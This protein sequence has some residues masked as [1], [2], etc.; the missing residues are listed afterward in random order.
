MRQPKRPK[1]GDW[2]RFQRDGDLV[3][4]EV[5]YVYDSDSYIYD[6]T[7]YTVRS[8]VA[9]DYCEIRPAGSGEGERGG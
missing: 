9:H 1:P 7:A 5:V 6:W 3:I 8:G 2:I 4:D